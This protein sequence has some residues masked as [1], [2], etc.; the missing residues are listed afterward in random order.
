MVVG[1]CFCHF[2]LVRT[3]NNRSIASGAWHVYSFWHDPRTWQTDRRTDG[4]C[5][6]AIAALMHSIA[7]QKCVSWTLNT[8]VYNVSNKNEIRVIL[9]TVSCRLVQLQWNL[10]C[11]IL[12]TLATTIKRV[13]NLPPR[14]SQWRTQKLCVGGGRRER[15]PFLPH[16]LLPSPSL[17]SPPSPA[18]PFSSLE[19]GPSFTLPFL[20]PSPPV[21]CPSLPFLRSRPP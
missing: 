18:L 15:L 16:P 21:P 9:S 5:M 7:R 11:E 14:L 19:V 6:T 10:A 2:V 1:N 17:P 8:A 20:S 3:S 12:M 4:H 13:H